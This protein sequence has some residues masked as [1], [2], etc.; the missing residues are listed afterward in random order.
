MR[1]GNK[2]AASVARELIEIGVRCVIVAG[3]AVN[4]A[5]ALVFGQAFYEQLLLQAQALRRR[6]VRGPQ[7]RLGSAARED[8]TW[9]AFQAYGDP[10][11]LA[12]PRGADAGRRG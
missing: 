9:G 11:W 12:E 3:W 8:I 2:L 5:W 6:G 1:D 10:G 4:D 7:G